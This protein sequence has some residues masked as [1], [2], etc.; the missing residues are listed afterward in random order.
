MRP[1]SRA[2]LALT[3]IVSVVLNSLINKV[4]D[5]SQPR[6]VTGIE[7]GACAS[8]L[9]RDLVER[10]L[11]VYPARLGDDLGAAMAD[12]LNQRRGRFIRPFERRAQAL[13]DTRGE[14]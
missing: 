12:E 4:H 3:S 13:D 6:N 11:H 1:T 14:R 5:H 2:S 10:E 9:R 8:N 7:I